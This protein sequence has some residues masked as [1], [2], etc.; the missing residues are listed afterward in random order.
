MFF[1]KAQSYFNWNL[2][3]YLKDAGA[4]KQDRRKKPRE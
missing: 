3:P 4:K 2:F 1:W